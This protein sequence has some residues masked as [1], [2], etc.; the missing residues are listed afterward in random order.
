MS[1]TEYIKI[2]LMCLVVLLIVAIVIAYFVLLG[3]LLYS[4]FHT[5]NL[6]YLVVFAL[7]CIASALGGNRG[8]K[9]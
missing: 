4:Y 5:H 3:Y 1:K 7:L 9:S 2:A 6:M 8:E